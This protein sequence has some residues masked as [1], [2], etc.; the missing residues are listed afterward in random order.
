VDSSH[1]LLIEIDRGLVFGTV[2]AGVARSQAALTADSVNGVNIIQL[3]GFDEPSGTSTVEPVVLVGALT[4]SGGNSFNL[5]FDVNDL[6][7]VLKQHGDS[8]SVTFDPTTGRAAISAPGGFN[9]NFV[10]AAAWYLYDKGKGFFV[11]IDNSTSAPPPPPATSITNRA[12]S[13][14]TLP[15][16]G[17]TPFKSSD[18]N[19]NVIVGFG[20]SSSPLVPNAELGLNLVSST[21]INPT[22]PGAYTALGDASAQPGLFGQVGVG[23]N[24]PNV[25]FT[26]QYKLVDP[27]QGYGLMQFPAAL[28]GDFT[29][30][31]GT[32]YPANFYMIAPNQFVAIGTQNSANAQFDLS[33]VIFLDPQ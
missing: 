25:Q 28:F 16:T 10:D 30:P 11:E 2:F 32:L 14:T 23:G 21:A 31:T 5:T 29:S 19:G 3:T 17:T 18:L 13:G 26:G 9:S 22:A 1:F 24:I 6:G 15:Q 33:G 27:A 12:L 4:V 7:T 20:A 8:G